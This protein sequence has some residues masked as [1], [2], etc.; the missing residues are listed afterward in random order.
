MSRQTEAKFT[1]TFESEKWKEA[2]GPAYTRLIELD[3][4]AE[5]RGLTEEEQ[6]E[7]ERLVEQTQSMLR[8]FLRTTNEH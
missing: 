5:D 4:I 2:S 1:V 3:M 7:K 8:N 6:A